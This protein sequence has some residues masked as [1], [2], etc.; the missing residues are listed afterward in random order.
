MASS[1]STRLGYELINPGE[2]SNSWG[3]T[4]NNTFSNSVEE[5]VAGVYTKSLAGASATVILTS[6]D[7][8]G[9]STTNEQ[10]QF[11]LNFINASQNHII[12]VQPTEKMF[13]IINSSNQYSITMRIGAAGAT[14]VVQPLRKV[15]IA[16]GNTA[17]GGNGTANGSGIGS[18]QYS[19]SGS[20]SSGGR[21]SGSG[22]GSGRGSGSGS[23]KW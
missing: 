3:A 17:A 6:T 15:L 20:G 1:Y 23:G 10:R 5:S 7:G 2:Q 9:A 13:Y 14:Q 11:A 4:T 12:Q 22:S 16:A 21:V 18:G 19:G 8:G